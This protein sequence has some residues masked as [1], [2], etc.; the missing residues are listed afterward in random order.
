MNIE[1]L[2]VKEFRNR[3]FIKRSEVLYDSTTYKEHYVDDLIEQVSNIKD[4]S[5]NWETFSEIWDIYWVGWDPVAKRWV[6]GRHHSPVRKI[7]L[8]IRV[9]PLDER[10]KR[11]VDTHIDKKD[12]TKIPLISETIYESEADRAISKSLSGKVV[13]DEPDTDKAIRLI[14][15]NM[16]VLQDQLNT[17]TRSGSL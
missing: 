1:K 5:Y 7:V 9:V 13:I 6:P 15:H 12:V 17:L 3:L 14:E 16:K 2:S 4:Q 10:T 11:I 8:P